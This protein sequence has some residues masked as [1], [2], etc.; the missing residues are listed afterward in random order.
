M[1]WH[2]FSSFAEGGNTSDYVEVCIGLTYPLLNSDY[3]NTQTEAWFNTLA[4]SQS[5]TSGGCLLQR[6]GGID[7]DPI[8][9]GSG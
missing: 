4:F 9:L 6:G 5:H 8:L 2:P 1:K 7:G 3:L